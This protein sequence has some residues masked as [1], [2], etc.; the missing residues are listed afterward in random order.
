MAPTTDPKRRKSS[1]RESLFALLGLWFT[2]LIFH[3]IFTS[4]YYTSETLSPNTAPTI[5]SFACIN[6]SSSCT[7]LTPAES[8]QLGNKLM[9]S[10]ITGM[11]IFL[12]FVGVFNAI[13]WGFSLGVAWI[14]FTPFGI[15]ESNFSGYVEGLILPVVVVV[16]VIVLKEAMWTYRSVL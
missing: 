4:P 10:Q 8:Y 1:I 14:V 2:T 9:V 3:A 5:N 7:P 15:G 13:G 16:T 12:G 11:Q 6:S